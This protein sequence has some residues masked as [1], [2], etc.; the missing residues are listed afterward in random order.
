MSLPGKSKLLWII[1]T[2]WYKEKHLSPAD[3]IPGSVF[4]CPCK[5]T[6]P[7]EVAVIGVTTR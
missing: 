6:P 2:N 5:D 4:I 3:Q 1:H 7:G